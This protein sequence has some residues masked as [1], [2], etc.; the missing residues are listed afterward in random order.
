MKDWADCKD[1]PH[2]LGLHLT[3]FICCKPF[4]PGHFA[5]P[6]DGAG[7]LQFL[8]RVLMQPLLHPPNAPHLPQLPFTIS[9][10]HQLVVTRTF[11]NL[12][13]MYYPNRVL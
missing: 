1:L 5:P 6:T 9:N 3:W 7:L 10:I 13:L 4:P 8:V 12:Q 2:I 11:L